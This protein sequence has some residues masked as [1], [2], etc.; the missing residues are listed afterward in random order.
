MKRILFHKKQ[1][2]PPATLGRRLGFLLAGLIVPYVLMTGV[3]LYTID[4]FNSQYTDALQNANTAGEFNNDFKKNLDQKMYYYVI[5]SRNAD[6]LPLEDVEEARDVLRKLQKTTTLKENEWRIRS[7]LNLCD[8]LSECMIDIENT[9][10]YDERQVK[11]ETNVDII[12][13]LI[14]TYMHDY[15]YDEV[16]QLSILQQQITN[17]VYTTVAVTVLA[18]VGIV[19]FLALYSWRFARGITRPIKQLCEKVKRLGHGDF[20]VEPLHTDSR[21]LRTLDDGFNEMAGRIFSLLRHVQEDQDALRRAEMELLQAQI[22][23]HFLYN[24]F[25]SIIWLAETHK[26]EEVVQIVTSLSSFF[27]NSLSKGQDVITLE[28]EQKQVCSYL[29]IQQ[30]RYRDVLSYSISI[31]EELLGCYI[32]KLTLQPLVE[33]AIYH[34]IRSKREGGTITITGRAEGGDILLTVEDD[35]AGMTPEQLEALRAGIYKDCHTGLGLVNVH[36]RL[37]LYCGEG[38]GLSFES[39]L[40]E[41]TR[42]LVRI[43]KQNK[44]SPKKIQPEPENL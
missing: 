8:R 18:A 16:R 28:T 30:I 23:P 14:Q 39:R 32:P 7:M 24:T 4:R 9:S 27:R 34:G 11:L 12:T 19:V 43:P 42:V 22:N 10:S 26:D 35:G 44:L 36:R 37:R 21:E 31:P 41:G 15:T 40:G 25:D 3:F 29:E 38:Y 5:G 17:Q 13:G 2:Q 1:K 33:N 20:A 6:H